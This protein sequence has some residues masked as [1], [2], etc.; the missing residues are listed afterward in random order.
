M[1]EPVD[2]QSFSPDPAIWV[3]VTFPD[4]EP[5]EGRRIWEGRLG[6]DWEGCVMTLEVTLDD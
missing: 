2:F 4:G 1:T 6:T 5:P 3:E